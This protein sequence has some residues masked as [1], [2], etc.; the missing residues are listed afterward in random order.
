MSQSVKLPLASCWQGKWKLRGSC[1]ISVKQ[2]WI[3]LTSMG[4][5]QF[6]SVELPIMFRI[7]P[8]SNL[9]CMPCRPLSS[10]RTWPAPKQRY[11]G[12]ITILCQQGPDFLRKHH[13]KWQGQFV[14]DI[15]RRK[16]AVYATP[17]RQTCG[18]GDSPP[19]CPWFSPRYLVW[20]ASGDGCF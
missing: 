1:M 3:L 20:Y 12:E 14:F 17:S 6:S 8:G 7:Q 5:G 10:G 13:L 2:S 19:W 9:I 4:S 15:L 11:T 16:S 18:N